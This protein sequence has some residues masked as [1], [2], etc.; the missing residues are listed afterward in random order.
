MSEAQQQDARPRSW[1]R[2]WLRARSFR[3]AYLLSLLMVAT[4]V[5][6]IYLDPGFDFALDTLL[7]LSGVRSDAKT[8]LSLRQVFAVNPWVIR[9]GLLLA[10][11]MLATG[12]NI[13]VICRSFFGRAGGR[14]VLS[15]LLATALAAAWLSLFVSYEDIR[16]AGLQRRLTSRLPE[17]TALRDE[18]CAQW[19]TKS[20][21]L[22]MV[23]RFLFD[24]RDDDVLCL[25][26]VG[27]RYP[28]GDE[29]EMFLRRDS[30]GVIRLRLMD[31]RTDR[32]FVR[33]IEFTPSGREPASYEEADFGRA[34]VR[35]TLQRSV[36]LGD[37]IYLTQYAR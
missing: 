11:G 2:R 14:T 13:A 15:L 1:R 29:V 6:W 23:G 19:P 12:E 28:F 4:L 36:Q 7:L 34:A 22:P 31:N 24:P 32:K 3:V 27:P 16:W 18:L 26:E 37:S 17:L 35:Y 9:C 10:I 30:S 25:V 33:R 8:I 5:A 21:A 20:G